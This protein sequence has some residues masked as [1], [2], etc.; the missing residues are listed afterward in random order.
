[1]LPHWPRGDHCEPT[2]T[3]MQPHTD[4]TSSGEKRTASV[5]GSELHDIIRSQNFQFIWLH[6]KPPTDIL[7]TA[8]VKLTAISLITYQSNFTNISID[9]KNILRQLASNDKM[10]PRK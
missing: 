2:T 9:K 7:Y 1:M 4:V 6:L 8:M 3:G 5:I 10:K